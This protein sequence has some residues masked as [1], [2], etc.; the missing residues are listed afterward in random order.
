MASTAL[1]AL[2]LLAFGFALWLGL[3]LLGRP[4]ARPARRLAGL[5]LVAYA[6]GLGAGL[7]GAGAGGAGSGGSAG[8]GGGPPGDVLDRLQAVLLT[9]PAPLWTGALLALRPGA[10]GGEGA[11][12]GRMPGAAWL[13]VQLPAVVLLA[14]AGAPAAVVAAC[15]LLPLL[16]AVAA[17]W[18]AARATPEVGQR[19]GLALIGTAVL[20]FAL[21]AGL[22]LFPAGWLPRSLVVLSLGLDLLLLG[23]AIAVLDAFDEGEALLPDLGRSAAGA[24][25][26]A[27]LLGL[28]L[29]L[30]L[31]DAADGGR[32]LA[33]L[34]VTAGT[35]I[36]LQTLADPLQAAIDRVVFANAPALRRAR[37]GLREVTSALPR[38][39]PDLDLDRLEAD[40][41]VRLTRQA[42]SHYG[43]LPRLAGSPLTR[44]PLVTRRLAER[45][46]A[47]D[48]LERAAELKA[49]LAE[50][51]AR[52]KPRGAAPFGTSDEWRHYNALYFPYVAGL[53]PYSRRAPGGA[54]PNGAPGGPGGTG[55]TGGAGADGLHP[56]S[57]A[58][59]AWL[60]SAVPERT[61]HHWQGTAARAVAGDLRERSR[62]RPEPV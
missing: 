13:Y 15:A 30:T 22:L 34:L 29:G 50:S 47:D 23:G 7:A 27:V 19:R 38:V 14:A 39:D 10:A 9:L 20:F 43:D 48:A 5:G 55:G 16:L 54:G 26:A 18:R 41:F 49:V 44:L 35:G 24:A 36:A 21:A 3:Y 53:R 42:L 52:L 40:A 45:G 51:I 46:A 57:A 37:A 4:G 12:F 17:L 58:A 56:G 31:R 33:L 28:P 11:A 6:L 25:V 1:A 59:L 2:A 61:L 32:T 60:R 62:R 8:G